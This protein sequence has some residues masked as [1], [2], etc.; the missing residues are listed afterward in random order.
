M[1][2][3]CRCHFNVGLYLEKIDKIQVV[4]FLKKKLIGLKKHYNVVCEI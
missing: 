3:I 2:I 1:I 4:L